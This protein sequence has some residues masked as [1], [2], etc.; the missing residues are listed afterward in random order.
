VTTP[1]F[2]DA[3]NINLFL[4]LS[5]TDFQDLGVPFTQSET[6]DEENLL[7]FHLG[8][9]SVLIG[10]EIHITVWLL[11]VDPLQIGNMTN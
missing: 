5:G 8:H 2:S 11:F 10:E 4:L 9:L 1:K 3:K 7:T 6:P